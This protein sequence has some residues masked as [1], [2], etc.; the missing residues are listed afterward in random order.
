MNC[1]PDTNHEETVSF[2]K[3]NLGELLLIQILHLGSPEPN[4]NN[5]AKNSARLKTSS[6]NSIILNVKL[7]QLLLDQIQELDLNHLQRAV[8]P[9]HFS[10]QRLALTHLGYDYDLDTKSFIKGRKMYFMH[11]TSISISPHAKT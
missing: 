10:V 2:R 11:T 8:S 1:L 5:L 6:T 3:Q 4:S 7:N 9:S